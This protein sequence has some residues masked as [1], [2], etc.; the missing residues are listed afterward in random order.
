MRTSFG[1]ARSAVLLLPVVLSFA[2]S[3]VLVACDSE[4][5]GTE[6]GMAV[7]A[8]PFEDVH[9]VFID[10]CLCH[11]ENSMGEK[12]ADSMT[13]NIEVAYDELLA[14]SEQASLARVKPGSLEDSYL[15]H[16]I[17]GTHLEVGGDG[18]KMPLIGDIDAA[19]LELIETWILGGAPP[20]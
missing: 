2:F 6:D 18:E 19:E 15:W 17:K 14:P 1:V 11:F 20:P 4:D 10:N 13:L 12:E 16:K 5:A 3:S 9:Q 7:E 8:P